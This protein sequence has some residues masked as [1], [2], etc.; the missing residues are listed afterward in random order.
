MAETF[1]GLGLHVVLAS[2]TW[3]EGVVSHIDQHTRLLTLK[4]GLYMRKEICPS[5]LHVKPY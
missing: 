5:F 3:V 2:G 4:N 1:V